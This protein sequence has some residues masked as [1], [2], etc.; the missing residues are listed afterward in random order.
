MAHCIFRLFT[1]SVALITDESNNH[2]IEVEEEHKEVEA[3][4]DEGFLER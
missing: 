4:L 3:K 1:Q 2:A